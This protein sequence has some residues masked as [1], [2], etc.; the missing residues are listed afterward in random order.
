MDLAG[1]GLRIP[2]QCEKFY[3]GYAIIG[4]DEGHAVGTCKP[5][6]GCNTYFSAYTADDNVNWYHFTGADLLFAI[7][8]GN[9]SDTEDLAAL[10][11]PTIDTGSNY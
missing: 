3:V 5:V 10:G 9:P 2:V 8:I 11:F 1:T 4:A 7:E 6:A